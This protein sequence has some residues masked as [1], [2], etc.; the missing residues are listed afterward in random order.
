M[1]GH[2]SKYTVHYY[3]E[4]NYCSIHYIPAGDWMQLVCWPMNLIIGLPYDHPSPVT[5]DMQDLF[6]ARKA[7]LTIVG[8]ETA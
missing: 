5:S 7:C 3:L 8:L 6:G 1:P 2:Q 4:L